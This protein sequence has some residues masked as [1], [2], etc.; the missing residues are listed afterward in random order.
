[1]DEASENTEALI[2]KHPGAYTTIFDKTFVEVVL[3]FPWILV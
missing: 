1:M 3:V 2:L